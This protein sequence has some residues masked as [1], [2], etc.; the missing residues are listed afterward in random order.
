[1]PPEIP[2]RLSRVNS[3]SSV[4]APAMAATTEP[5]PPPSATPPST[6][7][8]MAENSSPCPT[9]AETPANPP[10]RTAATAADRPES[11]NA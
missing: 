6:T 5:R 4:Q 9:C 1:M 7:A 2:Y 11:M 10:S 3:A 8:V